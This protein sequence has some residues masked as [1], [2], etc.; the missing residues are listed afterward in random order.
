MTII[1]AARDD[2]SPLALA[3]GFLFFFVFFGG[4]MTLLTFDSGR[5]EPDLAREAPMRTWVLLLLIVAVLLLAGGTASL[6]WAAAREHDDMQRQGALWVGLVAIGA[7]L[8]TLFGVNAV[9]RRSSA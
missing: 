1:N 7:G 2:R 4:S 5:R 3:F 8:A 9:R 6:I